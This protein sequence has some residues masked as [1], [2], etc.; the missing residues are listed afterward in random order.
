MTTFSGPPPET[1]DGI[2]PLTLGGFLTEVVGRYGDREAVVFRASGS[3]ETVRWSYDDLG[4]EARRIGRGLLA[5]GVGKGTRVGLLMGNRPEWVAA[6]Y[7]VAMAGGVLVPVNTFYEPPELEH[8]LAHSDTAVLLLQEGLGRHAY[9]DQVGRMWRARPSTGLP[10]LRQMV[11]LGTESWTA[12]LADAEAVPE[13]QLDACS[14]N[15]SPFDDAVIIY[16]SGSTAS[17]KGVLHGHR[18]PSLQSWRF[19]RH[20]CLDADDRTWS[21]YPLFWSAGFGMVMGGTLAAGGCLVLQERFEAG[22]SL[23]LLEAERIT[24]PTAWPLQVAELEEHPD[25]KR[26]DLSSLRHVES[27]TGWGR[28]PSVDVGDAWSPR[29][30]YG[31]TETFTILSSLPADTP[32]EIRTGNQG[33]VLPGMHVRII[34]PLTGGPQGVDVEGGIAVKGTCLMK[35]YLKVAPEEC[36]DLDGFFHTGDAGFVDEHGMLHWTGR[37]D[38]LIKTAG[39]NVSP[40]EIETVLLEHPD[41]KA[42]LAVA[43]P[44]PTLG[45][46]VV[47]A[48]VAHPGASVTEADVQG[49]LRGRIASYKI[50]RRVLFFEEGDLVLTGNAKIKTAELRALAVARLAAETPTCG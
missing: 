8:V 39:A 1:E 11:C 22:E 7:G 32:P 41:L 45:E 10:H 3:P 24:T 33:A 9:L 19:V 47:L 17:P 5:A 16:T 46:M 28:H 34:D 37:T 21:P 18:A 42:A 23:A 40:V 48:A 13:R 43:V 20:L 31:L 14:A 26:R 25:W 6:A 4:R 27:F 50:P 15:V 30:A 36:F 29:A 35:G 12:F 44:H 2:G 38:D 49:F